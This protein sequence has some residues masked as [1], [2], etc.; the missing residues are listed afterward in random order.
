[1]D[2]ILRRAEQFLFAERV[3]TVVERADTGEH[4]GP[5]IADF[6]GR[7]H[8]AHLGANLEQRLMDATQISRAIIK[9]SNHAVILATV[10]PGRNTEFSTDKLSVIMSMP[11]RD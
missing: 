2:K 4:H 1:M 11:S 3:D 6:T 10:G 7:F 9:Q 8:E 5:G